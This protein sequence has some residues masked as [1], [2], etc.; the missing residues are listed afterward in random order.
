MH[1]FTLFYFK[2]TPEQTVTTR[3]F[4]NFGNQDLPLQ[5]LPLQESFSLPKTFPS[6]VLNGLK[7][8]NLSSIEKRKFITVVANSLLD[9]KAH[10]T[11][12]DCKTV[13]RMI[14]SKWSFLSTSENKVSFSF[15]QLHRL[16]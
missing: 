10:P 9:S 7:K 6:S 14:G 4:L 5:D 3:K 12:V 1:I 15:V 8:K 16:L 11:T 13:V 2:H